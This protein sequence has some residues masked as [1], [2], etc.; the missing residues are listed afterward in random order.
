M[1]SSRVTLTFNW[2]TDLETA[3][4]RGTSQFG[5]GAV[6]A[7]RW[8]NDPRVGRYDPNQSPIMTLGVSGNL[9]QAELLSLVNDEIVYYFERLG[10]VAA[11]NVQGGRTR[12]IRIELDPPSITSQMD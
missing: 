7:A 1:G 4:E 2:G 6:K 12:E 5:S 9:D 10:G 3:N 11:V 8:A